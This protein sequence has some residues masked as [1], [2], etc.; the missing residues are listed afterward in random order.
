MSSIMLTKF[1]VAER[2]LLQ[3]I[4]MF[5]RDDDP[6]SVH[7][8]SEAAAQVLSDIGEPF[9]VTSFIRENEIV[10]EDKKKEWLNAIFAAK[11]FFKHADR[12]KDEIHA[13]KPSSNVFSLLDAVNMHSKIKSAFTPE[14]FI[15]TTWVI[16][17][18]PELIIKE[19]S[20]YKNTLEAI[21]HLPCPEK[22]RKILLH[23]YCYEIRCKYSIK[24]QFRIW[25]LIN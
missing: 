14:T 6:V 23:N 22:K 13:F 11:N 18:Y 9:G 5:F 24:C 21:E 10:R 25:H 17:K 2:Q 7:T 1:D 19:S 8:L 16:L 4:A 15:F 3:A 20:F 12:D